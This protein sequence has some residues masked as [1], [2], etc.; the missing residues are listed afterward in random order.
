M[1]TRLLHLCH[2]FTHIP[3]SGDSSSTDYSEDPI[4]A[5]QVASSFLALLDSHSSTVSDPSPSALTNQALHRSTTADLSDADEGVSSVEG[6]PEEDSTHLM[7]LD[8]DDEGARDFSDTFE[9]K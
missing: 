3:F 6:D 2:L 7:E 5:L 1:S 8:A 4:A 9:D